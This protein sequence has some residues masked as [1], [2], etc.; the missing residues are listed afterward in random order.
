MKQQEKYLL[1]K[2]YLMSLSKEEALD[3]LNSNRVYNSELGSI[4]F[5]KL[6]VLLTERKD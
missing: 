5:N 6:K 1:A 3:E 4:N 2:D